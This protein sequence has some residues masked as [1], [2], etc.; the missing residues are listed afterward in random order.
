MLT[1]EKN[2][3]KA[4]AVRQG[5]LAALETKKP[6]GFWDA[7]LATPLDEIVAMLACLEDGVFTCVIGSRWLHLGKCRIRRRFFRHFIGRIFATCVSLKLRLPVYDTQCGAKIFT[8]EAASAAFDK[9]FV[10]RWFFD[11]EVIRRL[12]RLRSS[13]DPGVLEYPVGCWIDAPG[14]KVSYFRAFLDFLKLMA[15]E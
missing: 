11:V 3:G 4:E 10:T 6:C 7:D 9:P 8:A 2:R 13:E 5:M 12:Q 15:I 1:L 14:S